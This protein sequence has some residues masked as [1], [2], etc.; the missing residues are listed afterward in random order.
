MAKV[1]VNDLG[2]LRVD[3]ETGR[4]ILEC[5][6]PMRIFELTP[7]GIIELIAF[8]QGAH[9]DLIQK[10]LE[11]GPKERGVL[12]HYVPENDPRFDGAAEF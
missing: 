10:I 5:K 2:T 1:I 8:L 9:Q 4:L 7:D 6:T 12:C 3:G 11:F